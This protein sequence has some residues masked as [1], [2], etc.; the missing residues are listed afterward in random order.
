MSPRRRPS[1]T[2]RRG[3]LGALV[4]TSG[5]LVLGCGGDPAPEAEPYLLTD[6]E[7]GTA[8]PDAASGGATP[9]QAP[10]TPTAGGAE[11]TGA[12][13]VELVAT[14]AGAVDSVRV[15]I[16]NATP[17]PDIEARVS[18]ADGEEYD[19]VVR[20]VDG[21]PDVLL[22]RVDDTVYA[23][24]GADLT[25][26][27]PDDPRL[28]SS[29]GGIVPALVDWS[30]LLDLRAALAGA[31]GAQETTP[32]DGAAAAYRYDLPLG[33]RPRPSLVVPEGVR[34]IAAVTLLLD[35]ADLP[36]SLTLEFEAAGEPTTVVLGYS[37][38]GTPVEISAP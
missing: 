5:L 8:A 12:A 30:P 3:R 32:T 11:I 34:G 28:E 7:G 1:Q 17:P 35:E 36:I 20:G 25:A 31:R 27:D 6:L 26:V 24:T 10:T 9:S 2:L 18:Y 4:L 14:A 15:S 21:Q 38:W 22:R 23:G 37:D 19:A 33:T 29:A 16:S 13:L